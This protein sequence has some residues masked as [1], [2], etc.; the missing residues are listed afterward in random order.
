MSGPTNRDWRQRSIVSAALVVAGAALVL[1]AKDMDGWSQAWRVE[2]GAAVAL[3]GPIYFLEELLRG[4]VDTLSQLVDESVQ[5][6]GLIRRLLP[7]GA[8]RTAVLDGLITGVKEQAQAGAFRADEI[9]RL[10]RGDGETRTIALAAMQGDHDLIDD[11]AII[12]SI[13]DSDSGMEQYHAMKLAYEAWSGLSHGTR[14]RVIHALKADAAGRN[15]IVDDPPRAK[16]AEQIAG[17]AR[18]DGIQP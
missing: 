4:R 3:L 18:S 7:S 10:S 15:F 16:L 2:V 13:S 14:I 11:D 12:F 1:W 17:L 5:S 8:Q 6:Y 9:V